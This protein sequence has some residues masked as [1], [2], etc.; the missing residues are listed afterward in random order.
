MHGKREFAK[1]KSN[2]SNIPIEA[3]N[4]CNILPIP[5]D[6]NE[7]ITISQDVTSKEKINSSNIDKHEDFAESIHRK[8]ISNDAE[9][10]S[11]EDT[12]TMLRTAS[13]ETALV[14]VK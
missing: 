2:I 13:N 14:S 4:V 3:A 5:A 8:I 6:S 12:L 1:I 7:D 9:F 11:V 10:C